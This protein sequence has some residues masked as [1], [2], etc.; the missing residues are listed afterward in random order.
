MCGQHVPTI[1]ST[2]QRD[3]RGAGEGIKRRMHEQSQEA[4]GEPREGQ[5]MLQFGEKN[6]KDR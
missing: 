5:S 1:E 3:V 6:V 4:D 2:P